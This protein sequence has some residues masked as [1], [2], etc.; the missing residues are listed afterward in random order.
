[1]RRFAVALS[2][3][4]AGAL[5]GAGC[6]N[7]GSEDLE[8]FQADLA[9]GNEVPPRSTAAHGSVGYAFDGTTVSY[10]VELD[11]TNG[12]NV[13]HIHS[14]AAGVNGPVRVFLY[15]SVTSTGAGAGIT[16]ADKRVVVSGTFTAANMVG[17]FSFTDLVAQMRAGTAYTNFHSPTFPGGEVRGQIRP[18]SND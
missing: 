1:M 2:I 13:G 16:T 4:A 3:V 11:D 6:G 7:E 5:A 18:I 15:P 17:G 9:G 10:S 12:I 8:L 14:G